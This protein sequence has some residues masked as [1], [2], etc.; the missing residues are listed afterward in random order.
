MHIVKDDIYQRLGYG[1]FMQY[2]YKFC[3]KLY[4]YKLIVTYRSTFVHKKPDFELCLTTILI[5][6][7]FAYGIVLYYPVKLL[8]LGH[9]F[10]WCNVY[11]TIFVFIKKQIVIKD[12]IK[13][14]EHMQ[15]G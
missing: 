7:L 12:R 3:C 6:S 14:F 5:S 1:R 4:D 15:M 8:N 11:D 13:Y 9:V 10:S 2:Q